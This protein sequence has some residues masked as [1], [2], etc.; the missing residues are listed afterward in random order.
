MATRRTHRWTSQ[1]GQ[2]RPPGERLKRR[3]RIHNRIARARLGRRCIMKGTDT[4]N[5]THGRDRERASMVPVPSHDSG[6]MAYRGK[7]ASLGESWTDAKSCVPGKETRLPNALLAILGTGPRSV[8]VLGI[9]R[10]LDKI[11]CRIEQQHYD[12]ERTTRTR[13]T[14][15][16]KAGIGRCGDGKGRWQYLCTSSWT[17]WADTRDANDHEG[18]GATFSGIEY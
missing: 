18:H 16:E 13:D 1:G 4:R 10:C 14:D 15:R 9:T 3:R 8:G 6:R 5:R 12:G 17:C 2:D 11:D 7:E